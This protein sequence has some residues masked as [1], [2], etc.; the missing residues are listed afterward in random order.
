M[1]KLLLTAAALSLGMASSSYA[2]GVTEEDIAADATNTAQVVT[3][4]MGGLVGAI[5]GSTIYV[6]LFSALYYFSPVLPSAGRKYLQR[7]FSALRG[8]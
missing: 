3:N 4:G 7:R 5:I 1:R 2:A 6:A 8:K